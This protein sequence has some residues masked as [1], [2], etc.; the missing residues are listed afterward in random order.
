MAEFESELYSQDLSFLSERLYQD[1]FVAEDSGDFGYSSAYPSN[2]AFQR[3]SVGGLQAE[4][5]D[6]DDELVSVLPAVNSDVYRE[7]RWGATKR[8]I[9]TIVSLCAF[10][11]PF[12]NP[13]F[14]P[15]LDAIQKEFNAS[16]TAITF[17]SSVYSL[18][19]GILP[20]VW[21]P[22]SDV[23][24]RRRFFLF[25]FSLMIVIFYFG[26]VAWS[27][28]AVI[29]FR[30]LEA[31]PISSIQVLAYGVISDVY[32]RKDRGKATGIM[33][34][35]PLLGPLIGPV[36][37][38]LLVQF[39]SWRYS[40]LLLSVVATVDMLLYLYL[41]EE[42]IDQTK[43]GKTSRANPILPFKL[44]FTKPK[45]L[46][47]GTMVSLSLGQ[48]L[49]MNYVIS[50]ATQSTFGLT[51]FQVG[52]MM[53][54]VG[55]GNVVASFVGGRMADW[56][57]RKKGTGGR[58]IYSL[59]VSVFVCFVFPL[60]GFTCELHWIFPVV[61]SFIGGFCRTSSSPGAMTYCI[62]QNPQSPGTVTAGLSAYMFIMV[63]IVQS[64]A[65]LIY[66]AI[67]TSIAYGW[68][69]LLLSILQL[70]AC[71]IVGVLMFK[72]FKDPEASRS[73]H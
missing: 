8:R 13:L 26:T 12:A 50:T 19:L 31:I 9:L 62:E 71:A 29:L 28:Y 69:Y 36:L 47:V 65:P 68:V 48:T 25:N 30:F 10:V 33:S 27:I 40:F 52:L 54:P 4:D 1:E 41:V 39:A 46:A 2:E 37:G 56:G 24:G 11:A 7:E 63:F 66:E 43:K 45:V 35:V 32:P 15:G 72:D 67:G 51:G 21:G 49:L 61:F 58:L 20:L 22:A 34:A 55:L 70:A 42:T 53:V 73:S 17:A 64:V 44:L 38:G 3:P 18:P 14:L 5:E 6:E 23:W 60:F 59:S 16:S 57:R